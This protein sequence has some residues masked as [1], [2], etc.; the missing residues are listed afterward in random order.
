MA[1]LFKIRNMSSSSTNK[2]YKISNK[3]SGDL[4]WW[5]EWLKTIGLFTKYQSLDEWLAHL[6]EPLYEW[7][8]RALMTRHI[9]VDFLKAHFEEDISEANTFFSNNYIKKWITLRGYAYDKLA[10]I[11]DIKILMETL[12]YHYGVWT[13]LPDENKWG[14]LNFVTKMT[15]ANAPIGLVKHTG[16]LSTSEGY[17]AFDGNDNTYWESV[18]NASVDKEVGY[19]FAFQDVPIKAIEVIGE[20]TGTAKAR[21]YFG[22]SEPSSRTSWTK[23]KPVSILGNGTPQI[24]FLNE[25]TF[26][27]PNVGITTRYFVSQGQKIYKVAFDAADGQPASIKIKSLKFYGDMYSGGELAKYFTQ[28]GYSSSYHFSR[29]DEMEY[30]DDGV[31]VLFDFGVQVDNTV[32]KTDDSIIAKSYKT[33]DFD[34]NTLTWVRP[35]I[36]TKDEI[37]TRNGK[38][39]TSTTNTQ[40]VAYTNQDEFFDV[41]LKN[42]QPIVRDNSMCYCGKPWLTSLLYTA[43]CKQS[44]TSIARYPRT[45][46]GNTGSL[47]TYNTDLRRVLLNKTTFDELLTRLRANEN[48]ARMFLGNRHVIECLTN[49]AY[50]MNKLNAI[51]ELKAIMD[52]F[53]AHPEKYANIT[54]SAIPKWTCP[55]G[56]Y[57]RTPENGW[58]I[59]NV[60]PYE[61]IYRAVGASQALTSYLDWGTIYG[62]DK[63]ENP[64][65]AFMHD[66]GNTSYWYSTQVN[67]WVEF[68]FIKPVKARQVKVKMVETFDTSNTHNIMLQASNDR[69]NWNTLT[70]FSYTT[71]P[72]QASGNIPLYVNFENDTYYTNYRLFF[73]NPSKY[74]IKLTQFN[75][76]GYYQNHND[77]LGDEEK[78]YDETQRLTLYHHRNLHSNYNVSLNAPD[79]HNGTMT[80]NVDVTGWN[81]LCARN[82]YYAADNEYMASHTSDGLPT[83]LY[84][85][86]LKCY[87]D[88]TNDP[89]YYE[90]DISSLSGTQSL[91]IKNIYSYYTNTGCVQFTGWEIWLEK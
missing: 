89:F 12:K 84:C 41:G 6:D 11:Y 30:G 10:E 91:G 87:Y 71:K 31:K 51:P 29:Y 4:P 48:D 1:V 14:N 33:K 16:T 78:G 63:S 38:D 43:G 3:F 28:S 69:I 83:Y 82:Y 24:L 27:T 54:D 55:N 56:H 44:S 5:K 86:N 15:A 35:V 74:M 58:Y 79:S 57:S 7:Q 8:V 66:T 22:Y 62:S 64:A 52:D 68:Q 39:S 85:E 53:D 32:V 46:L 72:P 2:L 50:C 73:P 42:V 47:Y 67:S 19:Q 88:P 59:N 23:T 70:T 61:L 9:S 90:L 20:W 75:L 21:I 60:Q 26:D 80:S 34:T 25:D 17:Y 45:F 81:K 49:S 13:Y 37:I 36:R 18:N 76:S 65:Y 77:G 40:T